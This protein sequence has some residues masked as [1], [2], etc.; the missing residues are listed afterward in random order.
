MGKADRFTEDELEYIRAVY[1]NLG[2]TAIS[3][4]LGRSLSA[5]KRR[6]KEM[7][8][9]KDDK[10][11]EFPKAEIKVVNPQSEMARLVEVRDILRESLFDCPPNAIAAIS[12]EYR[13]VL[14]E[15]DELNG[16]G[17][18]DSDNPLEQLAKAIANG[19]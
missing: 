15:I 2:P 12:K 8:L 7:G 14:K 18:K 6:I 11:V 17:A 4:K 5:V 10:I 3:R 16:K 1:P 13:A 9:K 19:M